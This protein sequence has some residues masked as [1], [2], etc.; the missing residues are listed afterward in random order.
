[1]DVLAQYA[2]AQLAAIALALLLNGMSKG[3]F[4]AG[5]LAIPILV[6]F[7]PDEANAA[8]S[9]V[10]FMLPMLCIMDIVAVTIYRKNIQWNR[11]GRVL[12]GALAGVIIASIFFVSE[13]NAII[14]ISDKSLKVAIGVVGLLF[15][16]YAAFKKWILAHLSSTTQPHWAAST[17]FGMIAGITSTLAHA[18]G[19]LMQMYLLP[20]KL[21]KLQFA[22]TT[23]AFFF[24]L[25]LIKMVPFALLG[26]IQADNL[27]LGSVMLPVIPLGVFLGYLLVRITK[28][29]HYTALI[30]TV[31]G[32]TSITLIVKGLCG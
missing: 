8:R 25:N 19:P 7:W 17:G 29:R 28:Q 26:R 2:P 24:I 27:M 5:T 10:G 15:V 21:P 13:Q 18:A 32:V 23:A 11:I 16:G 6:L 30:Y 9:A 12:P 3:G 4:P 1:M 22:A 14:A 31:L 20:Q